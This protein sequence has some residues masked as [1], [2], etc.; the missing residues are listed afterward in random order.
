MNERIRSI[1]IGRG[2]AAVAVAL[3]HAGT[4]MAPEQYSGQV[5][6]GSFFDI[7]RYGVDFFFVLSG[8]IIVKVSGLG[9]PGAKA[10]RTF[11]IKRVFRI[12]PAY[13]A[14]L[15]FSLIINIFQR[16]R[17]VISLEWLV[18]Q[19]MLL[20]NNLFVSAAWTLQ[21]ELVFYL[22][23]A[24]SIWNLRLGFYLLLMWLAL[25]VHRAFFGIGGMS[26]IGFYE[27]IS[28]PY[29]VLFFQGGLGYVLME[30]AN[31]SF[32]YMVASSFAVAFL[33]F[34]MALNIELKFYDLVHRM[35][36]GSLFV[37]AL[38]VAVR[39]ETLL[40]FNLKPLEVL[41]QISYSVYLS[42]VLIIGLT[43]AIFERLNL[44][45]KLGE[46]V[47]ALVAII[48]TIAF[49]YCMYRFI[50]RPGIG[51]GNKIAKLATR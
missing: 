32:V 45:Q 12:I 27:V 24:F 17:V 44:Y 23:C 42:N 20:D 8:Y 37:I 25:I 15:A 21:F 2:L 31:R 3:M 49:S 11:C 41:G 16:D 35:F 29:C 34:L 9:K 6:F 50:E 1:E 10:V 7:G 26:H 22:L 36:I 13:W 4:G 48:A 28:N 39:F 14:I 18:S 51:L 5:G 30:R 47:V 46:S 33:Y 43:Y 40:R 38:I 19:M